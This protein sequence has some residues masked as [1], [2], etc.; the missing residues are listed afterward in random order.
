MKASKITTI[1][2]TSWDDGF[3]EDLRLADMLKKYNLPATFYCPQQSENGKEVLGAEDLRGLQHAG[4]EIGAHT[5]THPLLTEI[6]RSQARTEI[7]RSKQRLQDTLGNEVRMFGYPRGRANGYAI[8]CVREAGYWGA[9]GTELLSIE[10][11]FPRFLM[12][13]S[14]QAI[15]HQPISYLRNLGR[16]R[17]WRSLYRYCDDL[18]RYSH[19]VALGKRLFDDALSSGGV[20]HLWGH[21][22]EIANSDLWPDLE[23]LL[24][25][26][27]G[28]AGVRYLNN[29]STIDEVTSSQVSQVR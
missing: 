15:P 19:W 18:H 8:R 23:R 22:W 1:V 6:S 25:Y 9:R 12:P 29:S 11:T 16:R 4:F 3:P 26:I 21:S 24:K 14:L 10:K 5:L 28:R 7:F 2:T 20:W 27:S 17:A 13:T